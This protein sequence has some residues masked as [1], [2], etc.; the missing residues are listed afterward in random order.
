MYDE[1]SFEVKEGSRSTALMSCLANV[2]WWMTF[3]LMIS[4]LSAYLVGTSPELTKVFIQ[5]RMLFFILLI[6]ELGLVI[7]ISAGINKMTASTAT[8]LF[9]LYAALNGLTLSFIFAVYSIQMI[10]MTFAVTAGTFA[11]MAVIGTI[12]KKDLTSFGNLF[13][14]ALIGLI[15]A[16]VV[17]LF[18]ANSTL[19]WICTYAGV[20]IFVGL[21]AYDANRI[22]QMYLTMGTD[23]PEAVRKVAVLGALALY[24]DFINL[25]LYLLRIFGR[26]D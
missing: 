7:W 22:K 18:W 2:Y 4:A 24:L 17:N 19:Y 15:I 1:S 16:S 9:I 3:A 21:T 8:A 20:L 5:N 6:A 14:M 23:N 11:A 25:F 26:R 12:T 13:F 10:A